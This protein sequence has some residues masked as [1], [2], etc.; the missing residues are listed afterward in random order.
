MP[1]STFNT[2]QQK[3]LLMCLSIDRMYYMT[4]MGANWRDSVSSDALDTLLCTVNGL[5]EL[6]AAEREGSEILL[7]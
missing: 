4:Y 2:K 3:S 7:L 5:E 6:S 1:F